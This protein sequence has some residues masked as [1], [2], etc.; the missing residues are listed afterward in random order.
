MMW[1]EEERDMVSLVLGDGALDYLV[2]HSV[3]NENL[4]MA[5]VT[6]CNLQKKLSD[7]VEQPNLSN[8]FAWNYAI[9]WQISQSKSG[10]L[11]G[12]EMF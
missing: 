8:N 7:L 4:L 2:N 1:S 12:Q 11:P 10:G 6:D 5:V 9:F 3:S